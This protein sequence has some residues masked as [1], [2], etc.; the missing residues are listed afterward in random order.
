MYKLIH[1][2]ILT[3]VILNTLIQIMTRLNQSLYRVFIPKKRLKKVVNITLNPNIFKTK[4][5]LNTL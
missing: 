5:F 3:R 2:T 4:V 1:R